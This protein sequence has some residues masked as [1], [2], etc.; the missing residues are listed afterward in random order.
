[1][2]VRAPY[3]NL[4]FLVVFF[5]LQHVVLRYVLLQI[6]CLNDDCGLKILIQN[7]NHQ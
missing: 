5:S 7:E 2:T 1:M 6:Q 3:Y 4:Y